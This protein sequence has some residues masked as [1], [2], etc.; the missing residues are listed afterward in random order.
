MNSTSHANRK[1]SFLNGLRLDHLNTEERYKFLKV[2]KKFD[3]IFLCE[4]QQLIFTNAIKH[5]I[6]TKDDLPVY[7]K[8]YRYSYCHKEEVKRQISKMLDEGIIRPSNSP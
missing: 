5:E 3:D 8:S 2:I 4:G 7:G 1:H 6:S